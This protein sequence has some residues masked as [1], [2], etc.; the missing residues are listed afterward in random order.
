MTAEQMMT[1]RKE[2][3]ERASL[4]PA[5]IDSTITILRASIAMRLDQKGDKVFAGT[6]ETLG[7]LT[8]EFHELV[9]AVRSDNPERVVEELQDLAV[10]CIIGCAS[11]AQVYKRE[12]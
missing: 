7:I 4:D 9:E 10:G 1:T 6:H 11:I 5:L 8:E 12:G 3:I 2:I